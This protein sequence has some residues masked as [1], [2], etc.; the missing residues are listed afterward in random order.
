MLNIFYLYEERMLFS[1][2]KEVYHARS[3]HD[4]A[5][6]HPGGGHHV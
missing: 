6:R 4:R 2:Y 3:K 1:T 5:P